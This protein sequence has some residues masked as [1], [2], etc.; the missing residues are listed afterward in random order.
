MDQSPPAK[1]PFDG[2]QQWELFGSVNN[3][4]DTCLLTDSVPNPAYA[5]MNAVV[6]AAVFLLIFVES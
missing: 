3:A 2:V 1:L 5:M 4:S 6:L